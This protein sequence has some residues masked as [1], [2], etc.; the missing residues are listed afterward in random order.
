MKMNLSMSR[1]TTTTCYTLLSVLLV[2]SLTLVVT[3]VN[4]KNRMANTTPEERKLTEEGDKL[5]YTRSFIAVTQAADV[6]TLF[7]NGGDVEA[8]LDDSIAKSAASSAIKRNSQFSI[9]G[10]STTQKGAIFDFSSIEVVNDKDGV[11]VPDGCDGGNGLSQYLF[12]GGRK[13]KF[14]PMDDQSYFFHGYCTVTSGILEPVRPGFLAL[15]SC[16]GNIIS[17]PQPV[18][19]SQLCKLNLCLG[20]GGFNCIAIY[21]GSAYVFNFGKG[22]ASNNNFDPS[23]RGLS[24]GKGSKGSNRG[25]HLSSNGGRGGKGGKGSRELN[26]YYGPVKSGGYYGFDK[27]RLTFKAPP[28]PP[29]FPG[30]IIGGT[31]TFE[32]IEGSVTVTTIAGTTGPIVGKATTFSG[33]DRHTEKVKPVGSIVQ[34]ITVKSNMPLPPGP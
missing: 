6:T 28:L 34:V 15:T 7:P 14:T 10:L 21:S 31:G 4:T 8:F 9:Q 5:I 23:R 25:R 22:I 11:L 12:A 1:R 17:F 13:L 27:P 16:N 32:G 20:G 3:P 19:T 29:P 33:G 30:T 18:I 26:Q 24:T 2:A